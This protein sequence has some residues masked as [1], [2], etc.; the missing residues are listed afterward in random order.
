MIGLLSTPILL[1]YLDKKY[2]N[3]MNLGGVSFDN[4]ILDHNKFD[5]ALLLCTIF[6]PVGLI[7]IGYNML[8]YWYTHDLK[9]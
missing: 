4:K 1:I 9:I 7:M 8:I 2:K 3:S 5:F 6:W